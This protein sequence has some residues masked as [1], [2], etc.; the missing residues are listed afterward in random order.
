MGGSSHVRGLGSGRER[1]FDGSGVPQLAPDSR[2]AGTATSA[3]SIQSDN[4]HRVTSASASSSL[5][6]AS[7]AQR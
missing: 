1:H 4:F 6:P 7:S 5:Q 2:L 3:R